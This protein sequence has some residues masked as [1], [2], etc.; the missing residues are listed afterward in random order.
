MKKRLEISERDS[1]LPDAVIGKI[2]KI[3]VEDK[4]VISLGPG[5][6]DFPVPKP[7]V[8]LI[9]KYAN[10]SNHYSPP[11]GRTELK[12][13]LVKKLKKD[14]KIKAKPENIIVTCGSQEALMLVTACTLDVSEQIILPNPGFMGY[15]P[16]FELF[17]ANPVFVQLKEEDSFEVNPDE[18]RKLIDKKKTK[19]LLINS[20]A[21]PTGNVIR[22]K[23]LE[24]LADIARDYSIYI[25]SDEAYEKITYEGK[26]HH[27][28][29]S[30][31]GMGDYVVTFQSFSKT[32]AMC[33]FRVG[34][35]VGPEKLM[36]AMTKTHIYSTICSPTISQKVA[37]ETLKISNKYVDRMVKEYAR[38]RKLILKRLNELNLPAAKPYGA[39]YAFPNIKEYSK[40]SFKFAN[41]LLVKGKVA[42]L[43]GTEFGRL[44]EGY[45]RFS[46]AT[47]YKLIE[48]AMDRLEKFLKK[49]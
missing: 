42:G 37:A 41:D 45:M 35:A 22:K 5:E 18:V 28:I 27:S 3:A 32:Y 15:L 10:D 20:P 23:V 39:F 40:D 9:K 48:Q 31:N 11:G 17:N 38:R 30:F 46:Y 13:A 25:F 8:N 2:L 44:G 26:K 16:T 6:P 24:E 1:Q 19:A 12:E 33:G 29:G 34:Y 47:D 14:N 36:K 49:Y 43:P 21:N 7:V 4:S